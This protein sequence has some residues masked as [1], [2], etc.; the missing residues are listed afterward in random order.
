MC[1]EIM[2]YLLLKNLVLAKR[3]NYGIRGEKYF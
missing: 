3:E 2:Y 1:L